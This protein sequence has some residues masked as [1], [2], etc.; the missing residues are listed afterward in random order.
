MFK[1]SYHLNLYSNPKTAKKKQG[2]KDHHLMLIVLS[3][4]SIDIVIIVVYIVVEGL[5]TGFE[6]GTESNEENPRAFHGV[7]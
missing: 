7:S 2:I 1:I 5:L 6:V 4:T 3:L